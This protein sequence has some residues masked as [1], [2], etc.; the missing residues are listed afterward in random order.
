MKLLNKNYKFYFLVIA[1]LLLSMFVFL[2]GCYTEGNGTVTDDKLQTDMDTQA[3]V[4]IDKLNILGDEQI[5]M[6][7]GQEMQLT[8]DAPKNAV[9]FLEWSSSVP[10]V[11]VSKSGQIRAQ[12]LGEAV[13]TVEYGIFLLLP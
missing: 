5:Y 13:I 2:C 6:T 10:F 4:K 7:V 9:N 1:L 3:P 8:T 11:Y 12:A